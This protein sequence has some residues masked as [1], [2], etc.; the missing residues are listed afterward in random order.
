[1]TQSETSHSHL[2]QFIRFLRKETLSKEKYRK[3]KN[4]AKSRRMLVSTFWHQNISIISPRSSLS[5]QESPPLHYIRLL[6]QSHESTSYPSSRTESRNSTISILSARYNDCASS[7]R[8]KDQTRVYDTARRLRRK[9]LA[10]DSS[11]KRW[12]RGGDDWPLGDDDAYHQSP[13][14]DMRSSVCRATTCSITSSCPPHPP[15]YS[16]Y[17]PHSPVVDS[18]YTPHPSCSLALFPITLAPCYLGLHL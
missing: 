13:H 2:P 15:T 8:G 5:H 6:R 11:R 9:T 10:C 7:P 17:T 3:H 1:M 4:L 18:P 14:H 12:R 16:P